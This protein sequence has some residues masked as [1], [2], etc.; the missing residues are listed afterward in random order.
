MWSG[1][2]A[3]SIAT[4]EMDLLPIDQLYFWECKIKFITL[5]LIV[6][7][8][9]GAFL[10]MPVKTSIVTSGFKQANPNPDS[11]RLYPIKGDS[12]NNDI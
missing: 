9:I 1:R 11:F 4:T 2:G 10:L 6:L 8:T 12:L 3:L 7:I 5:V